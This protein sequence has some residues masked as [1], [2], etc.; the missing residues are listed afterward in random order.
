MTKYYLLKVCELFGD[1]KYYSN[2]TV[3]E[4]NDDLIEMQVAENYLKDFYGED[5]EWDEYMQAWHDGFDR[6]V[7]LEGIQEI[8]EAEFDLLCKL[9]I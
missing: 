5:T 9:D 7:R 3:V 1:Y 8:T 6:W 4:I 2:I